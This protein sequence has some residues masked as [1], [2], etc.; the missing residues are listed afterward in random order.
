MVLSGD[1]LTN[2]IDRIHKQSACLGL[3]DKCSGDSRG[4]VTHGSGNERDG[5]RWAGR[6]IREVI[7]VMIGRGRSEEEGVK[8]CKV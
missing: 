6:R 2:E 3:A 1:P 8:V 4:Y 5:A 7:G